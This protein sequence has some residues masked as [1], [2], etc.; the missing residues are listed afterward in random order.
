MRGGNAMGICRRYMGV[1]MRN[2]LGVSTRLEVI[3]HG[4]PSNLVFS[5]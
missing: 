5:R 1:S 3:R 4:F 2:D